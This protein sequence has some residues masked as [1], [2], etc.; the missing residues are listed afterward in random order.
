[1][2]VPYF[3]VVC[4]TIMLNFIENVLCCFQP[5]FSRKAAFRWFAAIT[6]GVMLRSD[7]LGVTSIVRDLALN[8]ACYDYMLYFS[9]HPLGRW[10]ISGSVG[11]LPSAY[12]P[13]LQ[14]RGIPYP[15]RR[16]GE[17]AQGRAPY[18]WGKKAVPGI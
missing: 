3:P 2:S 10:R 12:T 1:M 6:I 4:H 18:A 7:R 11:S 9:G 8:L 5:C 15:C 14:R 13:P 17:A 16:W